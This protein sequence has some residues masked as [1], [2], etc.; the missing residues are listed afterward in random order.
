VAIKDQSSWK[1]A[2]WLRSLLKNGKNRKP[3][4]NVGLVS[5]VGLLF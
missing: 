3:Q 4:H 5:A 2:T 1:T